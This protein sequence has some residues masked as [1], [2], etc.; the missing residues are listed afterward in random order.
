MIKLL[1]RWGLT[2]VAIWLAAEFVPGVELI[3]DGSP[4]LTILWVA[5]I[6]GIINTFIKP[7]LQLFSFPFILITFGL[8][9]F[10]I[11][12]IVLGIT[13]WLTEALVVDGFV[14]ALLGSVV[15]SIFNWLV[16]RFMDDEE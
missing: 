9:L 4:W 2:G 11:N 3:T 5:F 8:F 14:A 13:G 1:V 15:I 6:F 10:V 12:A 7:I 16:S